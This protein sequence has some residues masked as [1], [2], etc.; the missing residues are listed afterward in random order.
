MTSCSIISRSCS[1]AASA[2]A[3]ELAV[4]FR[5]FKENTA[6]LYKST[7]HEHSLKIHQTQSQTQHWPP[8][9]VVHQRAAIAAEQLG[10]KAQ[11]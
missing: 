2:N 5:E 11:A 4:H 9:A 1:S 6:N 8:P 10:V 7:S 3:A